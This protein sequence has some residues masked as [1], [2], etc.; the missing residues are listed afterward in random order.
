MVFR[1]THNL[2]LNNRLTFQENFESHFFLKHWVSVC[3]SW[4]NA[5]CNQY[6]NQ[7]THPTKYN[8][9]Q[10]SKSY[11]FRHRGGS[12]RNRLE[13][14]NTSMTR[15]TRYCFAIT[16]MIEILQYQNVWC[17]QSQNYSVVLLNYVIVSRFRYMLAAV[18]IL[19]RACLT[20]Y[21]SHTPSLR[22]LLGP[23]IS[24]QMFVFILHKEYKFVL[25]G[26]WD[27]A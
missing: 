2:G 15:W 26:R 5:Q 1:I 22:C 9:L 23:H 10:V 6:I 14:W 13:Q 20:R 11:T 19:C 24:R 18:Y 16:G 27:V 8:S 3:T 17:W 7:Q 21:T 25:N 4:M 12:S